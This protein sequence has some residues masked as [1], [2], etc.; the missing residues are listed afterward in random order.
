MTVQFENN[1]AIDMAQIGAR[2]IYAIRAVSVNRV[3]S[4]A[5]RNRTARAAKAPIGFSSPRSHRASVPWSTPI[6]RATSLC[7]MPIAVRQRTIR[8][9][10]LSGGCGGSGL[11]PRNRMIAGMC[12]TPGLVKFVSHE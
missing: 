10:Q 1:H 8:S 12:L 3:E 11:Y 7:V 2:G 5:S 6:C 9:P 4:A